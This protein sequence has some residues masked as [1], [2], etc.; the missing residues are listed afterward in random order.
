MEIPKKAVRYGIIAGLLGGTALIVFF[1]FFDILQG[2]PFRTPAYLSSALLDRDGLEPGAFLLVAYTL[3]H[4]VVFAVLGAAGAILFEWA[5]IPKN[6]FVGA[7]FGLFTCSLVFYPALII[8]GSDVLAGPAWPAVLAGNVLAGMVMITYLR[9]V[10]EQ[11]GVTGFLAQLQAHRMLR[12]GL[13]AGLIGA[14]SVAVWFLAADTMVREPF[15]TPGAL[16]SILFLGAQGPQDVVVS[17]GTVL[18]YTLM[19]FAAFIVFGT[20]I[21]GIF[22]QIERFPPLVFAL[23]LLFV[24]FETFFIVM[25]AMLGSWMVEAL[26]WWV[27]LFGNVF[28]AVT[29]GAYL[30]RAHPVLREELK[31]EALWAE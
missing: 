6:L 13:I 29:M 23:L 16:G 9:W 19:H 22:T 11:P 8:T 3:L 17:T 20:I 24:V 4:Y 27:V 2:R 26:E 14:F 30:W 25:V 5:A 7:A 31:S 18:G 15:F 21:S 10:S 12:E 28:A 1:F